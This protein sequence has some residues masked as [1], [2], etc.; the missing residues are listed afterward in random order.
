MHSSLAQE[1]NP[2]RATP[3]AQIRVRRE[4]IFTLNC[5]ICKVKY[6]L[7]YI[8]SVTVEILHMIALKFLRQYIIAYAHHFNLIPIGTVNS[9]GSSIQM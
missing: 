8:D 5:F 6:I 9:Q 2:N 7:H 1:L 4:E 3:A